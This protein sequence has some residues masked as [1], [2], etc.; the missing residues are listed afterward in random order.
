MC[1][2]KPIV[3][4]ER[5]PAGVPSHPP[6]LWYSGEWQHIPV[7][8]A[9]LQWDLKPCSDVKNLFWKLTSTSNTWGVVLNSWLRGG[10]RT[11]LLEG[12]LCK[13][14]VVQWKSKWSQSKGKVPWQGLDDLW[15]SDSQKVLGS[16]A[17]GEKQGAVHGGLLTTMGTCR[18][19]MC[20]PCRNLP[21]SPG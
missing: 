16:P 8:E 10:I 9:A 13:R 2:W 21:L 17:P 20:S 19:A 11:G 18:W 12:F 5:L 7:H 1:H 14:K 6:T 3:L 15:I 4:L